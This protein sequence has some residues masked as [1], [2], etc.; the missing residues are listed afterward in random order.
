[1]ALQNYV[2]DPKLLNLYVLGMYPYWY[3]YQE[4]VPY[5]ALFVDISEYC[6]TQ[7]NTVSIARAW[8]ARNASHALLALQK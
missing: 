7:Y 1:M 5:K 8:L 4:S 2:N 6:N 3:D